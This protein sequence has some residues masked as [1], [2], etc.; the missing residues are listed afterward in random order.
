MHINT[1]LL[2]RKTD[3]CAI[4]TLHNHEG[5]FLCI[6]HEYE[7]FHSVFSRIPLW[8]KSDILSGKNS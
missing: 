1:L 2:Y 8:Q 3:R 5:C 6:L 7:S 4:D